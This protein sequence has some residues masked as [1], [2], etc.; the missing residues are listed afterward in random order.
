LEQKELDMSD[1][2]DDANTCQIV[3]KVVPDCDEV[4]VIVLM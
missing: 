1:V 4:V 3:G 2:F